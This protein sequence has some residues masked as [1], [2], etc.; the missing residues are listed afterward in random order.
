MLPILAKCHNLFG[1][2]L[3][4]V[5]VMLKRHQRSRRRGAALVEAA[6]V[7]PIMLLLIGVAVDFSRI[8][9]GNVTLSG[10]ARNG[11]LYEFDPITPAQS[12]Y[13]DYANAG[14]ADATNMNGNVTFSKTTTTTSG[15]TNVAVTANTNFRTIGWWFILP[16]QNSVNRTVVVRK[17][18]LIPD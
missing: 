17:A 7:L 11:A 2:E 1:N 8:F 12:Y 18:Q 13:T 16:A 10:S 4:G 6:F 15:N 9:Y 14:N 3:T 5:D